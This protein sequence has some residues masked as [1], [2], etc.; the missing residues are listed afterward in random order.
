MITIVY[1]SVK[2]TV[3]MPT[4]KIPIGTMFLGSIYRKDPQ[5][6][7]LRTW[8]EVVKVGDAERTWSNM[9]GS[10]PSCKELEIENYEPVKVNIT[11]SRVQ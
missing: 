10:Q 9:G 5:E 4:S 6:L 8:D 7:F 11:M 3:A 2:T 1:P